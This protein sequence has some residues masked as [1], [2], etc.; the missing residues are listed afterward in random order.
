MKLID[1]ILGAQKEDGTIPLNV[2]SLDLPVEAAYRRL[3]VNTSINLIAKAMTKARFRT[4]EAGKI[5]KGNVHYLFNVRPN[6][7]QNAS[8][9]IRTFV[10]N[11]HYRNEALIVMVGEELFVADSWDKTTFVMKDSIYNDVT[12]GDFKFDRAFNESEVLSFSLNNENIV[13]VIDAMYASYGKL[14]T[15]SISNFKKRNSQKYF[16][17]IGGAFSQVGDDQADL[18]EM[19]SEA[20]KEFAQSEGDA[21]WP[22]EEGIKLTP[23][24]DQKEDK[25][26]SREIRAVIDDIFDFTAT[27]FHIPKGLL[28]GDV[29]D[30]EAMTDN[31]LTFCINPLAE[32]IADEINSKMY[33]KDEYLNGTRMV[34]DTR[35]IKSVDVGAMANAAD[36]LLMS[37]T[38]SP[39]E[40][41]DMMGL[42]P[43][44]EDWSRQYYITKNYGTSED[45]NTPKGGENE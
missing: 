11:L 35:L 31:F 20:F 1:W 43:L 15:A 44:N 6:K 25:T 33:T 26:G 39:D 17:E 45:A 2:C 22:L 8:E 32:M 12:V 42:E 23:A 16:A 34:V 37:G 28:K 27:A 3:A 13:T 7:N 41:R 9:F 40:N 21:I 36:K 30:V 24:D 5:K 38:H 4:L 29:A 10:T 14:I 19:L 18:S